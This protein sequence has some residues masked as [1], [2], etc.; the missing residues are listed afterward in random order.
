M[1]FRNDLKLRISNKEAQAVVRRIASGLAFAMGLFALANGVPPAT[2]AEPV[3]LKPRQPA[4]TRS[5]LDVNA[6]CADYRRGTPRTDPAEVKRLKVVLS[7]L[8]PGFDPGASKD[9][10]DLLAAYSEELETAHP[11]RVLAAT[12]LA[13]TSTVPITF[14]VV[15]RVNA[16][17]CVSSTRR[18]AHGVADA[19]EAERRQ[20]MH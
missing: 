12:Y 11:D 15:E 2:G 7:D 20:M 18:F 3:S 4:A 1:M 14:D 16:L 6:W 5:Y 8:A 10:I 13:L 17:L 19:A 9:G